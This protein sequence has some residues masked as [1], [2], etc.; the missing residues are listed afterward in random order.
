[1][2]THLNRLRHGYGLIY[3]LPW[4]AVFLG[5][6]IMDNFW[7]TTT[8]YLNAHGRQFADVIEL[9]NTIQTA[10]DSVGDLYIYNLHHYVAHRLIFSNQEKKSC[11]ID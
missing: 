1:M 4:P 6:I 8:R 2:C 3:V 9:T 11:S 10:W 7:G 5:L